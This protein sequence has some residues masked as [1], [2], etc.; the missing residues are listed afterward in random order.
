MKMLIVHGSA[1]KDG[2]SSTLANEF[3]IEAAQQYSVETI[4]LHE[5]KIN[6]C[7]GCKQCRDLGICVFNDDMKLL[8]NQFKEADAVCF[9]SPVYWWGISSMLKT[10]LDRLY[11]LEIEDFKGKK[12]FLIVTGEDSLEG[13]QYQLLKEQFNAICEY[14][15]MQFA[16]YLPVCAD[17]DNPAKDNA[18]ALSQARKLIQEM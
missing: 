2:N 10:F 14:T 5:K 3:E 13:I 16:G 7:T 8:I 17:D 6:H 18:K 1:R 12:F 4:Y 11:S 15:E 9:A